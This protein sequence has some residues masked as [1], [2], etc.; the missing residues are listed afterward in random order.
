MIWLMWRQHRAEAFVAGLVLALLAIVLIVTGLDMAIAYQKLGVGACLGPSSSANCA[1]IV[2]AFRQQYGAW[3]GLLTWLNLAPMLLAMLVG[4]PLVARELEQRT[5]LTVW[6]QSITRLRWVAVKLALILAGGLVASA[7]LTVLLS[8]WRGPFDRLD[9]A[10][11]PSGFDFEG[12]VPLAY[13]AYAFA[14]AIATGAL[15]RRTIPAMAVTVPGFLAVRLSIL[16]WA[17]PQYQPP[18]TYTWDPALTQPAFLQN[19]GDW[20]IDGSWVDSLGHKLDL[21]QVIS[22]CAPNTTHFDMQPGTAF[23]QCT[24]AHGW[25]FTVTWQPAGRFWLF[26]GIEAA[27]FFGLSLALVALTIWWVRRRIA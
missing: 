2:E 12:I 27:N 13:M 4:A 26:Q 22:T 24:H 5:H 20:S 1:D 9:G 14:L 17:R 10:F 16:N 8:W 25:L 15:L 11:A 7:L 18:L 21:N 23:T 6:T 3:P 19:R